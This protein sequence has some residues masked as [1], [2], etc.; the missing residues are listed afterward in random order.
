MQSY[1]QFLKTTALNE[2]EY[3]K[4]WKVWGMLLVTACVQYVHVVSHNLVYY[5]S[6][7]YGVY[8]GIQNQLVDLGFKGFSFAADLWFWPNFCLFLVVALAVA[9]GVSIFFTRKVITNPDVHTA[10]MAWRACVVACIVIPLRCISFLITLLPSPAEHCSQTGGF[11]AP[12]TVSDIFR[13]FDL[14]YGCGDL[15]FSG[16]QAYGLLATLSVHFYTIKGMR[17]YS[18]SRRE[19][20]LKFSYLGFCWFL[21]LFEAYV[22]GIFLP[23]FF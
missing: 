19:K 20:I 15:V 10:Q 18:P 6:S 17:G 12:K 21:V 5:L 9:H 14:D 3:W 2:L 4:Y 16:H 1:I 13:I 23:Q 11:N 22:F 8:G 7:V